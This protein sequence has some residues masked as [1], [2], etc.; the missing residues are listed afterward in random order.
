MMRMPTGMS[1]LIVS[2][3]RGDQFVLLGNGDGTFQGAD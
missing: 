3:I 1:D 2:D